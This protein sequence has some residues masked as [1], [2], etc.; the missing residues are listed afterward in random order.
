VTEHH[1]YSAECELEL[2]DVYPVNHS[3]FYTCQCTIIYHKSTSDKLSFTS[4][5]HVS[6]LPDQNKI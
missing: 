6:G 2:D 4:T 5:T 1:L 3:K